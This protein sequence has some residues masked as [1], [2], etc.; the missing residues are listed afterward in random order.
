MSPNFLDTFRKT[1]PRK[2]NFEVSTTTRTYNYKFFIFNYYLK[3]FIGIPIKN[4]SSLLRIIKEK[5]L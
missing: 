1:T 2:K 5:E 4:T 3:P